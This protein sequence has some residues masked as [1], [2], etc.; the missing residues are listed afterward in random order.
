MT[1]FEV[2]PRDGL[3]NELRPVSLDQKLRLVRGLLDAGIKQL[4]LG[5]FVRQ[6]RVPKMADSDLVFEAFNDESKGK[7]FYALVPNEKGFDRAV[8]AGVKHIAVFKDLL[9]PT[10]E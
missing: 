6:D 2:G 9:K 10:L 7:A 1:V 5:A 3:Q 4:E 8:D